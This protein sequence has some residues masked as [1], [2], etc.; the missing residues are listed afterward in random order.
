MSLPVF[1]AE[2]GRVRMDGTPLHLKGVSWFGTEGEGL[3]PDGLWVRPMG[4]YLDFLLELGVNAVR[5]PLAVDSVLANPPLPEDSIK[6]EPRLRQARCAVLAPRALL[7]AA[8]TQPASAWSSDART[9]AAPGRAGPADP[10]VRQARAARA[11]RHAPPSRQGLADGAR[12][13]ARRGDAGE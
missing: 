13:V 8:L 9:G 12:P 4:E 6:W 2:G 11:A 5:V 10:A 3:A 7:G 1:T